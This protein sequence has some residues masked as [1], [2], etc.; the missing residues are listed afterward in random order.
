M[1]RGGVVNAVLVTLAVVV[2]LALSVILFATAVL[3]GALALPYVPPEHQGVALLFTWDVLVV[4]F[5]FWWAIGLLVELQRSEV[6]SLDRFLHLPVSLAGVFLV[7]YVS[8][9]FSVA[10]V[11]LLPAMLGLCLA[12]VFVKGPALLLGL[13]LLAS[14]V[15]MVTALTYQ[16]QGWLATLM[17]NPRRRRTVIVFVTMGFILLFQFPQLVHFV[18]PWIQQREHE[19]EARRDQEMAAARDAAARREITADELQKRLDKARSDAKE[20]ETEMGRQVWEQTKRTARVVNLVVPP[21]WLP[22][23]TMAAAEGNVLP[24]LLGTLAMTLIGSAS[25]WR[26]YGTTRRLYTGQYTAGKAR[27]AAPPKPVAAGKPAPNLLEKELPWVPE[28]VAAVALAGY[29]SLTRA[30]E[31]KILLLPPILLTVIFG[32]IFVANRVNPP[33]PVRPLM[34]FGAMSMVLLMLVGVVGN[35]FGFDRDGFR[36]FVLCPASRRDVLFGKNLACAPIALALGAILVSLIEVVQPMRVD[37]FLAAL[38]QLVSMYL[39][40]CLL[41][42]LLSILAPMRMAPGTM[43]PANHRLVPV[44]LQLAFVCVFPLVMMPLLVPLGIEAGLEFV[45]RQQGWGGFLPI[46]LVAAV[47]FCV[48]VVFLYRLLLPYEGKLLQAREQAILT[49]ITT[50]D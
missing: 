50:R 5:L 28:Q 40:Y 25:L 32:S 17:A 45:L 30:P 10:L 29:R 1:R 47:L 39:L 4:V 8:S 38:V 2:I 12:Q 3:A 9:L 14:F 42:N 18:T 43:K 15:L 44:L 49:V 35:Q 31:A 16:F 11:V 22:L 33:E 46:Y 13:P 20:R 24:A 7:N 23:G 36:V 34:A 37:H 27:P 41:A 21:G 26:A 6:L 19:I 48:G